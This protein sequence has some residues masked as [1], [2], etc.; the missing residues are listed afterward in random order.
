MLKNDG[1]IRRKTKFGKG[2][3]GHGKESNEGKGYGKKGNEGRGHVEWQV[4]TYCAT[5]RQMVNKP[6][7]VLMQILLILIADLCSSMPWPACF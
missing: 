5:V 2:G 4:I 1:Q 7:F 3:Q 6:K